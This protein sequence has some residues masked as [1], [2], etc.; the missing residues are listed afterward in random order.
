MLLGLYLINIAFSRYYDMDVPF[1]DLTSVKISNIR[2][3]TGLLV[4]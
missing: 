4:C 2:V 3:E 1:A